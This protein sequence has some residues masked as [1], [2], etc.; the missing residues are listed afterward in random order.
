MRVLGSPS[1]K[2][3]SVLQQVLSSPL[4]R[5]AAGAMFL[6]GIGISAAAPQIVF[7]MVKELGASLP[8]AGLYYLTSLTVPI[9]GY[10]VGSHSDRTGER[11]TLFR[12]CALAGFVGWGAIALSTEIWMPFLV[13]ALVLAFAGAAASQLFAAVRDELDRDPRSSSDSVVATIRT[14]FTV[15]FVVGP[16]AGAWLAATTSLRT[17]LWMT[18]FCFLAQIIPVRAHTRRSARR[19]AANSNESSIP[20]SSRWNTMQPLLVFTSL[21]VL[22]CAGDSVK[23]GFLPLYMDQQLH[24]EPTVRG[25]V[26]GIQQLV[27]LALMPFGVML[28]RRVGFLW[29]MCFGATL[30]VAANICFATIANATGMFAGQILMGCAWS[31]FASLGIITAQRLLP[32]AL[33]TASAVFLSSTALGTA[34]GGLTGGVGVAIVGL[35]QVFFIPAAFSFIAVIGLASMARSGVLKVSAPA[36]SLALRQ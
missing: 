18:A 6:S 15:G 4:Y 21:Y 16:V 22:N 3:S 35:P 10:F 36:T 20:K 28:G 25:A 26:I 8:V 2:P 29:L 19:L 5:G 9:A 11:L 34:L 13:S 27:E 23:F 24:L 32:T 7:F 12:L 1:A 33:A 30:C 14:A 17:M 31:I